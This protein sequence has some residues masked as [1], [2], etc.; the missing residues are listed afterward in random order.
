MASTPGSGALLASA[1]SLCSLPIELV[2]SIIADFA[3]ADLNALARTNKG[4]HNTVNPVLYQQ[5]VRKQGTSAL[6]WACEH[7]SPSTL[8]HLHKQGADFNGADAPP[9]WFG[10]LPSR[11]N[12]MHLA[13]KHGRIDILTWLLDNGGA[14]ID[15]LSLDF[16]CCRPVAWSLAAPTPKWTPLHT[17]VCHGHTD[18]AIFL[19]SRGASPIVSP[20]KQPY[21]KAAATTSRRCLVTDITVLHTAAAAN[22]LVLIDQLLT[23]RLCLPNA[24]DSRGYT[25]LHYA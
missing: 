2:L 4:F 5:N 15:A 13:A 6:T 23:A 25:P 24:A 11:A 20:H 16:C 18:A 14:D 3:P 21:N 19:L 10:S 12:P 8:P 9:G 1:A 22:D 17:A 7:N